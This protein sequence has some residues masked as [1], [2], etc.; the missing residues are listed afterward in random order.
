MTR[1]TGLQITTGAESLMQQDEMESCVDSCVARIRSMAV[2]WEPILA[3]SVWYQAVGALA[4]AVAQKMVADVMDTAAIGQDDAYAIAQA[5]AKVA[6]L[7]DL[8][9]PSRAGKQQQQGGGG[10]GEAGEFATTPQYAGSWLRLKYLSEVLQSNL[11]EVR[12]LWFESELGLYF[13]AAEVVE[14]IKLSF[15]D[16]A[17]S[18]EVVK[19][20]TQRPHPVKA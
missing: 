9:L 5:I 8:F 12:Y 2:T 13:S 16:N 6:E 15:E 14:L 1:T 18:R 4:D 3:R 7:D 19:E 11:N 20:V 17:R 10:G